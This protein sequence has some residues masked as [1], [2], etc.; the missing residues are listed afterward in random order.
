MM[1]RTA[2]GPHGVSPLDFNERRK[3][4]LSRT[5]WMVIGIVALAHVGVGVAL[6]NQRFE[7]QLAPVPDIPPTV[8]TLENIPK[9]KPVEP[10]KREPTPAAPN[11]VVNKTPAPTQPT[12]TLNVP[13][14]DIPVGDSKSI[15]LDQIVETPVVDQPPAVRPEPPAVIMRANW[16]R[17]PT[18]EQLDR[19]FPDR[20]IQRGVSGSASLNCLVEASGRVNDCRVTNETPGGYG[21]GRA[22]QSVSR[23]FQISPQTVNGS[24]QGSRVAMTIRFAAPD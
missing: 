8:I 14:A 16:I 5:S 24:A 10:V 20:A 19:A 9:L 2:G 18:A 3:P 17:Q 6:Y 21:F 11:P 22:A 1:I 23:Y 13:Q 15:T 4:G 12:D 7:L